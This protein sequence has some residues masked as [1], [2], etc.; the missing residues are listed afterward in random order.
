M[1]VSLDRS[2]VMA[3]IPGLI[4][5][6]HLG[7]GLGHEFLR[8][9]ERAGIL[10]HL[11]EP[12]PVDGSDPL[13]NYRV[14]RSELEQYDAQLAHRPEIVILTKAELPGAAEARE[15]L[16]TE[17]GREVLAVSAVTGQGLDQLLR[18]IIRILDERK[19]AAAKIDS[20]SSD[21]RSAKTTTDRRGQSTRDMVFVFAGRRRRWQ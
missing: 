15:R 17:L 12:F 1:Q 16:S 8:H 11:V 10:V 13:E 6:A 3:D 20:E 2:F 18:E 19:V 21:R 4:E 7:A 9:V 5:G 14:V